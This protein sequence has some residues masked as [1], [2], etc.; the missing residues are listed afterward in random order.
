MKTIKFGSR[1]DEDG[2]TWIQEY[3]RN[4]IEFTLE[5]D[6]TLN[7]LIGEKFVSYSE[8]LTK[9]ETEKLIKWLL[10]K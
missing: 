3:N 2:N 7:V 5:D 6:G 8:M 1:F 9:I 10:T 4:S